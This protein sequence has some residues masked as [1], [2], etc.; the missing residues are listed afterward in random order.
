MS[1]LFLPQKF[2]SPH[3]SYK[4]QNITWV[5]VAVSWGC[6]SLAQ[7]ISLVIYYERH[8]SISS[9][10]LS[11]ST[12]TSL[13]MN[14]LLSN[15]TFSCSFSCL[16]LC[17][18]YDTSSIFFSI[19]ALWMPSLL[20]YCYGTFFKIIWRFLVGLALELLVSILNPIYEDDCLTC[21]S[22]LFL[23]VLCFFNMVLTC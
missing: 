5:E 13:S 16:Y 6:S 4:T 23:G 21:S 7:S 12:Y 9:R 20:S 17:M 3:S 19:W 10:Y 15:Y 2:T 14:S 22:C 18:F 11:T 1:G 8:Y